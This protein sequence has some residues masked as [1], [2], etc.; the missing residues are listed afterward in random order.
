MRKKDSKLD[1]LKAYIL[2]DQNHFYRLAYSYTKN[3]DD[4]ADVVQEAI[5][6]AIEKVHTLQ[7]EAYVKTWF[8]RIVINESLNYLRKNNKYSHKEG[9][10]ENASYEDKDVAETFTLFNAVS[11][12]EPKLRTVIILRY[13]EDLK[14]SEIA[15]VTD[16][17]LNT[18]K[19]RLYKALDLLKITIGSDDIE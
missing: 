2:G 7:N 8:Y 19:S 4:A 14:L 5:C 18:V 12:L 15:K 16:S 11:E 17:N 10:L 6:K 9:V 1:T 3:S 13:Y